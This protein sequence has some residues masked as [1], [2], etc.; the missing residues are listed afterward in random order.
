M[1][2]SLLIRQSSL[3]A[4]TLLLGMLAGCGSSNPPKT[5]LVTAVANS[6]TIA[7]AGQLQLK[8]VAT[9]SDG[10]TQD[11]TNS[12]RWTSGSAA[13]ATVDNSGLV[14]GVGA[15]ITEISAVYI[16]GSVAV[17]NGVT[18]TVQ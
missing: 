14:T 13:V 17:A 3:A 16:S 10:K 9:L 15:G 7:P 1:T 11:V 4:A 2:S 18:V 8:A 5:L 6:A 12:A